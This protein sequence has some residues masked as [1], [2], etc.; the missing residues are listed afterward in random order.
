MKIKSLLL[1][2]ALCCAGLFT[3]SAQT[4]TNN[5]TITPPSF[6]GGITEILSSVGLVT[7]PTNYA[8]A[9]FYGHSLKGNQSAIGLVII[10]NVNNNLGVIAG[11]DTLFGGGKIGSANI[12]S[13]GLTLK[14]P[15]HPLAFIGTNTFLGKLVVTPYAIAMV[16]T[17]INGTGSAN[18]GL[19]SIVR[20]GAN[21]D[22]FKVG[23][24]EFGVGADYGQRNG[25]GKYTGGWFDVE[26]SGRI[27][28]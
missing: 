24:F 15:T 16:G 9:A 14:E 11:V 23:K 26:L 6:W 20:A 5:F 19:A 3:V 4:A 12:V 8:A 18:G 28:F 17:P 27:G 10:E 2:V 21:V 25:A 22:I 13:G 7:D 1:A